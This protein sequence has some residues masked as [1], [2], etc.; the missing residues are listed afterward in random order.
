MWAN[1]AVV[2]DRVCSLMLGTTNDPNLVL[3]F[4]GGSMSWRRWWG[5]SSL[6]IHN[7]SLLSP[8]SVTSATSA[9]TVEVVI[10]QRVT[11][12]RVTS[13]APIAT[14]VI[15]AKPVMKT[16]SVAKTMTAVLPTAMKTVAR[17]ILTT[18]NTLR[19]QLSHDTGDI[20][21]TKGK[22]LTSES[23]QRMGCNWASWPKFTPNPNTTTT[24]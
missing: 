3:L 22:Q 9:A 1:L 6:M 13:V 21:H 11:P 16:E 5:W 18:L 8:A 15:V 12:L 23:Q 14:P 24:K 2:W 19:T 20:T 7:V 10:C 17:V 4:T